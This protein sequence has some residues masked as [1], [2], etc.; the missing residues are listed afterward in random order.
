MFC[1]YE[2]SSG[3]L[4]LKSKWNVWPSKGDGSIFDG[5]DGVD[6]SQSTVLFRTFTRHSLQNLWLGFV[7]ECIWLHLPPTTVSMIMTW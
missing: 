4:V 7:I 2:T 1:A 5:C 3:I 6:Q